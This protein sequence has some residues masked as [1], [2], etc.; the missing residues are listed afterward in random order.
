ML[1][2]K[3]DLSFFRE[4]PVDLFDI[5][6]KMRDFYITIDIDEAEE[7]VRGN[8]LDARVHLSIA[9]ALLRNILSED[10]EQI[11]KYENY[12]KLMNENLGRAEKRLNEVESEAL[13]KIDF[14]IKLDTKV[15]SLNPMV[16][17]YITLL[18][19]YLDTLIYF[20]VKISFDKYKKQNLDKEL[21]VYSIF[22]QLFSASESL[23]SLTAEKT[24]ALKTF[25]SGFMSSEET[26][27]PEPGS[28]KQ[29]SLIKQAEDYFGGN[30]EDAEDTSDIQE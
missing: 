18:I 3:N 11:S 5:E 14:I 29:E 23:G 17:K 25:D 8:C 21:F 26:D 30:D 4:C 15:P 10:N 1:I 22:R 6:M 28:L 27:L 2:N 16:R 9:L 7:N 12:L 19:T 13:Q 24:K 20:P